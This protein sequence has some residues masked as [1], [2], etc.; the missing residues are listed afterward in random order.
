MQVGSALA[1]RS[2]P[3]QS[4]YCGAKSAVRG[5]TDSLRSE[6]IHRRTRVH[7]TMVHLSAFNTPQFDWA[8]ACIDKQPQPLPPTFQPEVA[9]R[10]IYWAATHR[11]T[12]NGC[13]TEAPRYRRPSIASLYQQWDAALGVFHCVAKLLDGSDGLAG[14]SENDV[15][16]LHSAFICGSAPRPSAACLLRRHNLGSRRKG[17][18]RF[19]GGCLQ[20]AEHRGECGEDEDEPGGN[21]HDQPAQLLVLQG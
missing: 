20:Q 7:V 1:Y 16:G 4:A 19:C 14:H 15:A 13:S 11:R 18:S 21:P 17:A 5:F 3:L 8:R 12:L 2:I 10:G 6:L 9:A